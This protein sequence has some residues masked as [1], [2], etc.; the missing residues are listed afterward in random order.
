[1]PCRRLKNTILLINFNYCLDNNLSVVL[2]FLLQNTNSLVPRYNINSIISLKYYLYFTL[3]TNTY[4]M[5]LIYMHINIHLP[6][7]IMA[8]FYVH[9][10][11]N[12]NYYFYL[13]ILFNI[14]SAYCSKK[15]NHSIRTKTIYK[16]IICNHVRIFVY[17]VLMDQFYRNCLIFCVYSNTKFSDI[18]FLYFIFCNFDIF[19]LLNYFASFRVGLTYMYIRYSNLQFLNCYLYN[20]VM[21]YCKYAFQS[22]LS[23]SKVYCYNVLSVVILILCVSVCR[24]K[25]VTPTYNF[26]LMVYILYT[27]ALLNIILYLC[28]GNYVPLVFIYLYII[29]ICK[30]I[31]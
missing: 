11:A 17:N 31:K 26:I 2:K 3:L 14:L 10:Y 15:S 8:N 1:M 12:Y 13:F 4:P 24:P 7:I 21:P 20:N 9:A 30:Y 25:T 19:Y 28:F 22:E 6:S 18:S 16:N 27:N 5:K 29:C 23:I